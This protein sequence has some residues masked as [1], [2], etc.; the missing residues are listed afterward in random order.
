MKNLLMTSFLIISTSLLTSNVFAD[1]IC[2]DQFKACIEDLGALCQN[3]KG[4]AQG[5]AMV[6]Q[7]CGIGANQYCYEVVVRQFGQEE[8]DKEY[9]E[10]QEDAKAKKYEADKVPPTRDTNK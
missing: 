9:K 2:L 7:L 4:E 10:S 6:R 8:C 5:P 1:G 3:V